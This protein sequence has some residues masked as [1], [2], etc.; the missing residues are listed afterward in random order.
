MWSKPK[1]L[2]SK[3]KQ[4]KKITNK[5]KQ[6][7]LRTTITQREKFFSLPTPLILIQP[8]QYVVFSFFFFRESRDLLSFAEL[9]KCNFPQG[10][11]IN[12][13]ARILQEGVVDHSLLWEDERS[14]ERGWSGVG[15]K[16]A[17]RNTRAQR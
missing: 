2:Q 13:V 14:W 12:L 1:I 7:K 15:H 11:G 17:I 16:N 4:N 5:P 8:V 10:N 9:F 6:P 3:T